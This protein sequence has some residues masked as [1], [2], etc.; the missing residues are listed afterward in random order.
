M[1]NLIPLLPLIPGGS[2]RARW[3][4]VGGPPQRQKVQGLEGR[5][6]MTPRLPQERGGRDGFWGAEKERER[7][8]LSPEPE[9]W[10]R[11]WAP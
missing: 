8:T 4:G 10:M 3:Q 2:G 9:S 11:G 6:V 5:R 1:Q 7:V